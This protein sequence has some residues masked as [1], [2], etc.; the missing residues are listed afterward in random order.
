M[1]AARRPVWARGRY[2]VHFHRT[3]VDG[4]ADPVSISDSVVSG[5]PGWG[6][7]NHSSNV[8]VSDNVVF[9]ATGAAFVTEAG[10]ELGRFD[11]NIAIHSRGSGEVVMGRERIQDFGR[12]R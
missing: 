5:S 2:A 9:N 3:G 4:S 8:D 7:V 11:H 1:S 12:T 6:I 10:N